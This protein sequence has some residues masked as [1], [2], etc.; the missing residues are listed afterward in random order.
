VV[1]IALDP[2]HNRYFCSGGDAKT[3]YVLDADSFKQVDAIAMPA[4][5]DA[6]IYEPKN[7]RI[8][9]T[10]DEGSHVWGIDPDTDKVVQ[11]VDIPGVPEYMVYD[12]GNNRI[13]LNIKTKDEIAVI[14]PDAG[15]VV[16][17]WS[18]LPARGP[19]GLGFDAETGRLFSAGI[20]G[21]L[22]VVDIKTGSVIAS[23][24]FA[25]LVDQA[26][27]DPG[28]KRIYCACTGQMSVL[29]ETAEGA[30]FVGNVVT[31]DT[32]KNVAVDP[33]TRGLWTT[34]TDGATSYA[35]GWTP[36]AGAQ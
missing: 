2:K 24:S 9:V 23:P 35:K 25:S 7:G 29:Q 18:T 17:T 4:E 31:A 26:A 27:F 14:D 36:V 33:A 8:Y 22:A 19:H 6:L 3:V 15:A 12:A 21:R 1:C 20:N 30:N 13:Y 32:A 28:T 5:T 11:D 10:N 34:Y 16:T